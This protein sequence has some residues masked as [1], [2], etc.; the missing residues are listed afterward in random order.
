MRTPHRTPDGA[1][2]RDVAAIGAAMVAVGASFGA[3]AVAAGLPVWATVAMSTVVYAGGAQ[4][5]AVGLVAAGS[6]LAA[7]L[8]GLLLNARHLPFGLTLGDSLGGQRWRRLLGSHLMTD[9]ATAFALARPVGAARRQAFWLAGVL[10]FLAWNAGTVLGV[11]AGGAVGDPAAL[12]L[13]AA[14]P[15]GLIALLLPSLREPETRRVALAGAALAVLATP[16][17]PAGLPVLLALAALIVPLVRRRRSSGTDAAA[18]PDATR[19]A[20]SGQVVRAGE[21]SC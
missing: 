13:D 17:L 4:F 10:L 12:G 21:A 3:M 5:M 20:T 16:V 11:L 1:M 7:V 2:L 8:A 19:D 6:P 15:A 9:E 18:D 14:F